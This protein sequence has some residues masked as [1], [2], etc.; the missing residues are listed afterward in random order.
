MGKYTE[1]SGHRSDGAYYVKPQEIGL[2]LYKAEKLAEL[3]KCLNYKIF[4][5]KKIHYIKIHK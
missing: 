4:D 3:A 5:Q 1:T 2:R